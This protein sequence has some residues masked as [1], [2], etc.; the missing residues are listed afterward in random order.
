[1]L[2]TPYIAQ[3][4]LLKTH[5]KREFPLNSYSRLFGLR[6]FIAL[7][8][9]MFMAAFTLAFSGT[10]IQA[11]GVSHQP[12][13]QS[14][15]QGLILQVDRSN[16]N[17]VTFSLLDHSG[18]PFTFHLTANTRFAKG[19]S[20]SQLNSN[21]LVSVKGQ[22]GNAGEMDAV[23]IQI[24]SRNKAAFQLQG[25]VASVDQNAN[26]ITIALSDGTVL[27]IAVPHAH[28]ATIQVGATLAIKAQFSAAGTLVAS[29][30][31]IVAA[32]SHF[33][34]RG[35]VSHMNARVHLLTLVS[36]VGA[37]FSV[38][39]NQKQSAGFHIGEKLD[40]SG[41]S[42][43]K[44]NLQVQ[45]VS[46]EDAT[47]QSLTVI[48]MV[49][50]IDTTASTFSLVDKQGNSSTINASS[51]LLAS[52]QIG[53]VYQMEISIAS[54]GS[55]T[56]TQILS[57]Q[58]SDQGN[59]L[60]LQGT[61]QFYDASS[62]LLN[63]STDD[64]QN[65][66]LQASTQTTIVNSDGTPGTLASGQAIHALVQLHTDGTYSVLK[67]E[68]QAAPGT[69]NQMT[70]VG[71]FLYYDSASGNLIINP[72]HHHR[73]LFATDSNTQV[74]GA[75]SLDNI[76]SWSIVKIT[77]QVQPDGSYL[78]TLVQIAG[79]DNQNSNYHTMIR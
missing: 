62:G 57:S 61:V 69:G 22:S 72:G 49:S 17:D 45:T 5:T 50:N 21:M 30:Y 59:M 71:F 64:G 70:F 18:T 55:M 44:G 33:Q 74:D 34:A 58:G 39:Q 26:L 43:N 53:G 24:Q 51:D 37:A 31:R 46:V 25:V 19:Q 28:I 20:A 65:F 77:A 40:I 13:H 35:I 54:D 48:G 23:T 63:M 66:S 4:H 14:T 7:T 56:L 15:Y 76:D 75:S 42:D 41:S 79:S 11:K 2:Y 73:L 68:I 78:A 32:H 12:A 1:M 47:S 60:S 27:T 3:T 16:S 10:A 38:V 67:I 52:L 8:F 9:C 36:P 29:T 6:T